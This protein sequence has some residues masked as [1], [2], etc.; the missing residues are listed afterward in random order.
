MGLVEY[1]TTILRPF[2]LHSTNSE[3]VVNCGFYIHVM[4]KRTRGQISRHCNQKEGT[5]GEKKV[6]S[7]LAG[8][9]AET[10]CVDIVDSGTILQ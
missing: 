6:D 8:C 9:N 1:S 3:A 7:L 2:K 10:D 4:S 5:K